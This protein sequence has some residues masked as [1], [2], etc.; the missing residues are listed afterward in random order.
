MNA[1]EAVAVGS[2]SEELASLLSALT[3]LRRGD[4]SVRLPSDWS[5][6]HGRVAEV[7]NDV[8]ERNAEM[9]HE[10]ARLRQVVGKEGKL[11]QRAALD[12][13]HGF[14]RDSIDCINSLIDDLV[15]PTSE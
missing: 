14:W 6:L 8:V 2:G 1:P 10:I 5:G 11:K 3:A 15:H 9:A 13:A 12:G 4:A 7:F